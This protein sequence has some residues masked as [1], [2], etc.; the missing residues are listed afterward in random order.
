[1]WAMIVKVSD[2][3]KIYLDV[4]KLEIVIE[5]LRN[6]AADAEKARTDIDDEFKA[7]GDPISV[8][9]FLTTANKKIENLE[10]RATAIES[11]KNEIKRLNESGLTGMD[12]NGV[13]LDRL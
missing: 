11:C 12:D 1:M 7:E 8:D 3:A 9:D 4:D 10:N 13:K 2:M 6:L 5:Q